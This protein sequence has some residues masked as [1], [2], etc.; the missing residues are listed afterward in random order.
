MFSVCWGVGCAYFEASLFGVPLC[1]ASLQFHAV[2]VLYL[3]SVF[4]YEGLF[5]FVLGSVEIEF[6]LGLWVSPGDGYYGGYC[7]CCFICLY[8]IRCKVTWG[9][10]VFLCVFITVSSCLWVL[11]LVLSL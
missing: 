3:F 5:F 11:A 7:G 10:W 9:G 8:E 4:L 6:G 1:R 2:F